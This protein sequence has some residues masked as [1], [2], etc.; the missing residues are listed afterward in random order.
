MADLPEGPAEG[1]P[2]KQ[3]GGAGVDRVWYEEINLDPVLLAEAE[4][5]VKKALRNRG[6]FVNPH[7]LQ[8]PKL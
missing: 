3:A 4:K 1:D 8:M 6:G 7:Q 5:L 2:G